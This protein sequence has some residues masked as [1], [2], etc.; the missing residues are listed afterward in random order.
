M[1]ELG[2]TGK[3]VR[4]KPKY[5]RDDEEDEGLSIFVS[6]TTPTKELEK[7]RRSVVTHMTFAM[8][9]FRTLLLS[10]LFVLN[11]LILHITD[12]LGPT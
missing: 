4:K 8:M 9:M 1:A 3:R 7:M 5:L 6:N 10:S 2:I 11:G 12:S